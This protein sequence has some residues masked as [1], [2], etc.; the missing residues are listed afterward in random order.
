MSNP[1]KA[2]GTA[3]ETACVRWFRAHGFPHTDR[4]PL[5]GNRDAGDL[6]LTAGLVAEIKAVSKGGT[7]QP[8][9]QLLGSWMAQAEAE[10]VNANAEYC[11]L[12]VKRA[13]TTDVARWWCYVTV[14]SM[15]L[16]LTEVDLHPVAAGDPV[17]MSV[18]TA[19]RL[20]RAA[21]Y[22]APLDEETDR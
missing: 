22:G 7:G 19:T 9:A 8:P 17:C 18:H 13:G 14:H 20:L 2:K 3:A 11:L 12:I 16:L 1:S 21:G 5:R 15:S 10:R 6:A 4:Q